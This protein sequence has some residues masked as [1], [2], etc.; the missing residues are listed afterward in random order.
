[1]IKL[2]NKYTLLL[3]W[4]TI[5]LSAYAASEA[6]FGKLSKAWTLNADGSQEFRCSKELTLFTHTAMN[7]TYGETFIV[8]NPQWQELKIHASYT[9]QKDGS[10]VKT[11]DNAFVEVLP[12]FAADAPFYNHLKEMVVVHTGLELGATI[13]LDYSIITKPGYYPALDIYEQIQE[14]SP[15]KECQIALSV[16]EGSSLQYNLGG[17]VN[18][19][20]SETVQDGVKK[21]QWIL[22]NLPATSREAFQPANKENVVMLTASTYGS[23][24]AALK[25][26]AQEV[27]DSQNYETKAFAEYLTEQATGDGQKVDLVKKHLLSHMGMS[28]VPAACNGYKYRS[29]DDVLRSAYGTL[30]EKTILMNS[31]LNAAGVSSEIVVTMPALANQEACGQS[32]YKTA[33][34]KATVDGK[35]QYISAVQ[36][37]TLPV[38]WRGSLDKSYTLNGQ[39]LTVAATPVS[40][41]VAKSVEAKADQAVGDRVVCTLPKVGQGVDS[42]GMSPLNSQRKELLELPN[43]LQEEITYTVTPDKGMTLLTPATQKSVTKPCGK[44]SLSIAQKG[45]KIE[46]VRSIELNK[47]QLTPAEYNDLRTLLNEWADPNNSL[48]LFKK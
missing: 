22:R 11:P 4:L 41:K 19:K 30:M 2:I 13:Y 12:S 43:L 15:I 44:F 5:T 14:T 1:M 40:V 6:Q 26:L 32:A 48:L 25:A 37:G 10:I 8:Y 20:A 45:D 38:T 9:K 42:W 28:R 33:F 17:K 29:S 46:V 39:E 18:A 27:K 34:I 7:G 35:P 24:Q 31:M 16:P 36:G 21:V 3:C 47:M 23:A